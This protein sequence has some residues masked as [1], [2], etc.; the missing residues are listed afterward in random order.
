MDYDLVKDSHDPPLKQTKLCIRSDING[1]W[2]VG[3]GNFQAA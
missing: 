1:V 2:Q 3:G